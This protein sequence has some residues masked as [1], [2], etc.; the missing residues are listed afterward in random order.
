MEEVL[1]KLSE[2]DHDSYQRLKK[3]VLDVS[4]L[5]TKKYKVWINPEKGVVPFPAPWCHRYWK[6]AF[7]SPSTMV[8]QLTTEE[9]YN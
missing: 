3:M 8:G 4:L 5:N 2:L 6:G 9:V 7:R 1:P